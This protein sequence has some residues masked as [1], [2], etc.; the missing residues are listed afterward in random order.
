MGGF[1]ESLGSVNVPI[2]CGGV[3]VNPGDIII[4]DEDGVAVIPRNQA[5]EILNICKNILKKEQS[6]IEDIANGKSL[7]E[8]LDLPKKL[9]NLNIQLP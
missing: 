9:E 3:S 4:G 7:F 2:S 6:M 8:L 1:K 5:E